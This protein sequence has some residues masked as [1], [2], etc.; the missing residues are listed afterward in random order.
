[1][2]SARYLLVFLLVLNWP[3]VTQT[4]PS[5]ALAGRS[6]GTGNRGNA[7][8]RKPGKPSVGAES[9]G[10]G[11][12]KWKRTVRCRKSCF[13][14]EAFVY[15]RRTIPLHRSWRD[16]RDSLFAADLLAMDG[17]T[18]RLFAGSS[19]SVRRPLRREDTGPNSASA[20]DGARSRHLANGQCSP[21]HDDPHGE[22]AMA[23]HGGH[24]RSAFGR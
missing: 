20:P 8:S 4:A 10:T 16:G 18:R 5:A 14:S 2:V 23:R 13:P 9:A 3:A 6:V 12:S 11:A 17:A 15:L 1:M 21:G 24:V 19:V 22:R 7:E